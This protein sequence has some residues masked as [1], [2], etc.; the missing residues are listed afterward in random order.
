MLPVVSYDLAKQEIA[1][2]LIE[3]EKLRRDSGPTM[4][5]RPRSILKSLQTLFARI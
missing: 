1:A 3:A 2:K 4:H 5:R